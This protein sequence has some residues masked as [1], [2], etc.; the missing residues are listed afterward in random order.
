MGAVCIW[1]DDTWDYNGNVF[2]TGCDN[3]HEFIEG[4]IGHNN[5][6]FCP[7]CGR[8]IQEVMPHKIQ[9]SLNEKKTKSSKR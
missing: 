4:G 3:R 9:E 5:Y 1:V 7:Y 6:K 2:D 8:K